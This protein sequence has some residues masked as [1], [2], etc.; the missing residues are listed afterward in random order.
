V[1]LILCILC[2]L[3]LQLFGQYDPAG[4]KPGSAAIHR[5]HTS[6][7]YFGDSV[8][9]EKGLSK[10]NASDSTRVS[11]G[12]ASDAIGS[13][14]NRTVSLGDGGMA[15]YHFNRKIADVDGP[16]F[17][18]F[19]NGFEWVGG[20]FLELAF[21]E[22]SSDGKRFVRF[23]AVSAADTTTQIENLAYMTCEWYHNLAG[24]HQ[25]PYGTSFDL[26]ELKD[27]SGLDILNISHVRLVDVV[28][29]LNDSFAR[30]DVNN[31][32]INDPWPTDF[33]SGGFD[34]DAIGVLQFALNAN[35]EA[36]IKRFVAPNPSQMSEGFDVL[37][38]YKRLSLRSLNG[39][40]VYSSD[41][42]QQHHKPKLSEGVYVLL[43]ETDHGLM[44][45]KICVL[46]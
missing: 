26:N 25:A 6:L 11:T 1:R 45:Q 46:P 10:I 32:K 39:A 30:R 15:T 24:K 34:L 33:E 20:Y 8:V 3:P 38:P 35:E 43:I 14:D 21:V 12:I 36:V 9:I 29:N 16:D 7:S 2:C 19:E 17:V 22:V 44:S 18:V 42:N 28:G 31:N 13:P 41:V 4:G 27:S 5:D 23:P 37:I 40:I